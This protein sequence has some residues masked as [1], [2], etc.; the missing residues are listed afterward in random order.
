MMLQELSKTILIQINNPHLA[1]TVDLI[2][3]GGAHT[4]E[5]GAANTLN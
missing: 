4:A 2:K 3:I 5:A 1:S